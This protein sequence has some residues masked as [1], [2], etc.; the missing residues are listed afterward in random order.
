MGDAKT[1]TSHTD[2][3]GGRGTFRGTLFVILSAVIFGTMPLMTKTLFAHGGNSYTAAFYRF[4][5]GGLILLFISKA[6]L[7]QK[8]LTDS[9]TLLHVAG[10]S[11]SYA[12]MLA[13]L[14]SSYAYMDTGLATTL[15]FLY[16]A[17]VILMR[18][19]F[20]R[21]K[22][23]KRELLCLA[24]ALLGGALLGIQS[25]GGS[26]LGMILAVTS[27]IAYAFYIVF[28]PKSRAVSMNPFVLAFWISLFA[29]AILAVFNT[30]AGT[31]QFP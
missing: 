10:L 12:V 14:Y 3:S 23:S 4:A 19:L 24:L 22:P 20:F 26:L 29:A 16:P 18:F 17:A 27:G 15:H 7:K 2:L 25:A 1:E 13:L 31:W 21:L 5:V 11:I 9:K 6:V 28:D 8:I 30:A